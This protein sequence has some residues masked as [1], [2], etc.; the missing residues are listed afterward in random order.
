M[1]FFT[2]RRKVWKVGQ[3][4][5]LDQGELTALLERRRVPDGMPVL[6]D[7][8]IR[9]VEPLCSWFR[10]LAMERMAPKTMKA[11]AHTALML[12]NFLHK[13]DQ[14]LR[15]AT[16]Q[17]IRD[18]EAWRRADGRTTVEDSIWDRDSAAIGRLYAYLVEIGYVAARP[19]RLV[20]GRTSLGSRMSHEVRVRHMELEQYLFCRDVR[21][22]SL[23]PTAELDEPFRGCSPQRNP[24]RA[25]SRC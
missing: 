3:V 7:E 9:P 12:L 10:R 2:D 24:R 17:D 15:S 1:L 23:L 13:W 20:R 19:W 21:F 4:A 16:E 8:A 18:F 6:L 11:Y 14:D 22:G 5:G 25:S